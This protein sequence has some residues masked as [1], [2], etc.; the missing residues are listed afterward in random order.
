MLAENDFG[1][2]ASGQ[3]I[4]SGK[5]YF[6]ATASG[7]CAIVGLVSDSASARRFPGFDEHGVGFGEIFGASYRLQGDFKPL[8]P[9]ASRF[10]SAEDSVWI[11]GEHCPQSHVRFADCGP[12]TINVSEGLCSSCELPRIGIAVDTTTGFVWFS[13]EG[14]WL[15]RD[16]TDVHSLTPET[17]AGRLPSGYQFLYAAAGRTPRRKSPSLQACPGP[18]T[19]KMFFKAS[20]FRHSPPE[21]FLAYAVTDCSCTKIFVD[22]LDQAGCSEPQA[23]RLVFD[24]CSDSGCTPQECGLAPQIPAPWLCK[25]DVPIQCNVDYLHCSSLAKTS[26]SECEC[27]RE[28]FEC[29]QFS[30]CHM[31]DKDQEAYSQLCALHGC[32][33]EQCGNCEVSCN[34]TQLQCMEE[35]MGCDNAVST[36]E[37]GVFHQEYCRCAA[38]FYTCMDVAGCLTDETSEQHARMCM[39]HD[40]TAAECG[41]PEQ[42]NLCNHTNMMCGDRYFQCQKERMEPELDACRKGYPRGKGKL[43]CTDSKYGGLPGC[44]YDE[45]QDECYTSGDCACSKEY[46]TCMREGCVDNDE[47]IAEFAETCILKGCNAEQCGLDTFNC[48][49]TGLICANSYLNCELAVQRTP[50]CCWRVWTQWRRNSRLTSRTTWQAT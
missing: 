7:P 35:Y 18:A 20:E 30:G 47:V 37:H 44:I 43:F 36:S 5:Y 46:F 2:S 22:C 4:S 15:S 33:A 40:C 31:E 34:A 23:L 19:V 13:L 39:T 6:E 41:A 29:M 42:F 1:G 17:S 32:T 48:N 8:G 24:Q 45:E 12:S 11:N 21:D 50:Q 16:Q 26:N 3:G 27:T 38:G 49:R 14:K 10:E 9:T 28:L 25:S